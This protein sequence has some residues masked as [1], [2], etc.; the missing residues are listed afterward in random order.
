MSHMEAMELCVVGLG[1]GLFILTDLYGLYLGW[2]YIGWKA[3][4]LGLR[5]GS[6]G[7]LESL[8]GRV[9]TW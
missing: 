4:W 3:T 5:D 2:K 9:D 7:I 8:A 6:I 1:K